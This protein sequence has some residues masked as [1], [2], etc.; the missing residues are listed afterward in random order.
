[1]CTCDLL[2]LRATDNRQHAGSSSSLRTHH[3]LLDIRPDI[4]VASVVLRILL[5][6]ILGATLALEIARLVQSG[7][8]SVYAL[9]ARKVVGVGIRRLIERCDT[10]C[11]L[12]GLISPPS[13]KGIWRLS[14]AP[15]AAEPYVTDAPGNLRST[16]SSTPDSRA[17][18]G[19]YSC[20][21]WGEPCAWHIVGGKTGVGW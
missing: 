14:P 10:Y 3:L 12:P 4:I 13:L 6:L 20:T 2:A 18:L 8:V 21:V 1:M 5:R 15:E 7:W 17:G 9:T 16:N 11:P 19:Q